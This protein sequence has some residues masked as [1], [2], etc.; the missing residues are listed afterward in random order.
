MSLGAEAAAELDALSLRCADFLRL[1]EGREPGPQEG[2]EILTETPPDFPLADKFVL[3]VRSGGEL[4]G[5]ADVLRG[6]PTA[7]VWWIGLLLLTPEG[8]GGGLGGGDRRG[9]GELGG[10]RGRSVAAAW[11]AIAE[12]GRAAV[13]APPRLRTHP[14]RRA[15]ERPGAQPGAGDGASAS[16]ARMPFPGPLRGARGPRRGWAVGY[17]R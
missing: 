15:A 3:G 6:Y 4:I 9:V 13:L 2:R 17:H 5:V 16:P 11:R 7:A 14:H 10:R 8:R 12:R 1:V